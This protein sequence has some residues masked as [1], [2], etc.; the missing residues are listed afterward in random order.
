[1]IAHVGGVPIEEALLPLIGG[2]AAGL[3]LARARIP[4]LFTRVRRPVY[5]RGDSMKPPS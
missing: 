5:G 2:A 1:M 4:Q 3:V